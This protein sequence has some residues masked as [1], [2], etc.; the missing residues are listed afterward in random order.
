VAQLRY[1]QPA[2]RP[3][4]LDYLAKVEGELARLI[5]GKAR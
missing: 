5:A 2:A 4:R 3:A 1:H